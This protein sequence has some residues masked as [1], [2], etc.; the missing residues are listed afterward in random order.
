MKFQIIFFLLLFLTSSA[1]KEEVPLSFSAE[2]FTEEAFDI[3]KT[4]S[5][6]EITI[7]YIKVSGDKSISK[8]INLEII[9]YIISALNIGEDSIPKTK[10]I[11]DA[12]SD[13]IK[14][15]RLHAADFPDMSA[16]YFAEINISE[17]YYSAEIVSIEMHQ[18]LYTG[19]AHG[20]G[21]TFFLNIDPKTGT[22]IPSEA[23]FKNSVNFTSFAEIKF[24]E[25][26]K[27]S[28]IE[29]INATGFWFEDERFYLPDSIGLTESSLILLYNQ[30]EIAS[31]AEGPI[32]LKIPLQEVEEYLNFKVLPS[33]IE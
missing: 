12:A 11:N 8:K 15:A 10:T 33:R 19:G 20:S 18:Y 7:N 3:C 26:Y 5:C 16:E 17:L 9:G 30:Y 25:V 21:N 4:V 14:V 32:E 1:C 24:R 22:K 28:S 31:Y 29:S 6:P 23:F 27:I 2:S 13:F